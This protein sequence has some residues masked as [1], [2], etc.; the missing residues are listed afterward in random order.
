MRR[1]EYPRPDFVRPLW[2]NLNGPWEFRFD[3][4]DRGHRERWYEDAAFDKTIEVP[5]CFQSPLSGIHDETF[6]D[7]VWYRRTVEVDQALS[8]KR[9]LLHIGACDYQ[10]EVYAGGIAVAR[11][12][13]GTTGFSADVTDQ[14][15]DGKLT[16]VVFAFDPSTDETIPR[17][18]QYWIEKHEIIWY[19]RTT[20]IWQ[21]VW[22]EAVP[23]VHL[24]HVGT[25][26][27]FDAGT[28]TFEARLSRRVDAD[29]AVEIQAEGKPFASARMTI[30]RGRGR[31][32][33]AMNRPKADFRAWSPEDPFLYDL[34]FTLHR[35]GLAVDRVTSYLGMRK[36]HTENGRVYLNNRPYYLR[37]VLDQGYWEEGLLTAPADQD[38]L[39]DIRLAKAMGFN[40]ARKHQKVEDPRFL[41][42]ADKEGFLVWGEIANA[43]RYSRS[44]GAALRREFAAAVRRDAAHPCI[45]AWVPLN[46]SWGVPEIARSVEQQRYATALYRFV[47]Q[48]D[49]TRPVV[50]ND[51]WEMTETDLCAIHNYS[52]GEDAEPEKQARYRKALS[53]KE[54]ILSF[55]PAGRAIYVGG[56]RH[57]GE[58][59]LLTEFGGIAFKSDHDG[60]GYTTASDQEGFLK[61]Y[62]RLLSDIAASQV[63]AGYCYTQLTDVFQ[64]K[65]GLLTFDR[66]PKAPVERIRTWNLLPR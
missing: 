28:V 37:L 58:P 45:V 62:G 61:T 21:T 46:E 57:Q 60:W 51:G 40:G 33:V 3:D 63:L 22:L 11:H 24:E 20:G 2:Q 16:I 1:S 50:M 34:V 52:H 27:D 12:T 30:A 14:V 25:V 26:P 42:H 5:F 18:K 23:E 38:F 64:E 49:P 7:R 15:K 29:M 41:Y 47:K 55:E 6:H 65:N 13:G 66:R 39:T 43:A 54:E 44:G 35:R 17:G 9:I 36:V 10:S 31:I 59:I 56:H 4:D 19:P 8:G 53:T 48:L 32:T